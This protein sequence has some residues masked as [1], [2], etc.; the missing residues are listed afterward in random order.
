MYL[1]QESLAYGIAGV[2]LGLAHQLVDGH[3]FAT[4]LSCLSLIIF[5]KKL[6]TMA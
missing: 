3:G 1:I 4:P 6:K 2:E 5:Y